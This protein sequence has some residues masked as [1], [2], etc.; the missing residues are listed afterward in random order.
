MSEH[1]PDPKRQSAH[2]L[3]LKLCPIQMVDKILDLIECVYF[4]SDLSSLFILMPQAGG[5]LIICKSTAYSKT[6]EM[7]FR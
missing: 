4:F 6:S 3:E 2:Q 1:V 7:K 5:S